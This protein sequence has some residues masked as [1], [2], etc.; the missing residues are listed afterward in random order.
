MDYSSHYINYHWEVG[1]LIAI[2]ARM[3]LLVA[4][5]EDH[6]L[7]FYLLLVLFLISCTHLHN[8]CAL[9]AIQGYEMQLKSWYYH[10]KHSSAHHETSWPAMA[11]T[12]FLLVAKG[13]QLIWARRFHV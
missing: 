11:G 10:A 6:P 12:Q 5:T 3:A 9:L 4:C 2:K 7:W 1:N 13:L 8:S